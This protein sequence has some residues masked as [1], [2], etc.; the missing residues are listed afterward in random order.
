MTFSSPVP[1]KACTESPGSRC[2]LF[3][4]QVMKISYPPVVKRV[5]TTC[6]TG[7]K[8]D[9]PFIDIRK[10]PRE[11][12]KTECEA[13]GFQHL[14]RD[15]HPRFS[16]P[17]KGPSPSVFN[18]SLG[19]LRMLMNDKTYVWSL[20]LHKSNENTAKKGKII[21]HFILQP[22]HSLAMFIYSYVLFINM[23][24]SGRGQFLMI[25]PF[26]LKA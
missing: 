26:D 18:T 24:H 20:L 15:L 22:Y 16:T 9:Y 11:V 12:L 21:A 17:P 4:G 2:M 5:I 14:P 8:H 7:I 13:L 23:L 25:S 3:A 6:L 1:Q 19:T 10:V